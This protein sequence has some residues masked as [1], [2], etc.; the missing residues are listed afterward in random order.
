MKDHSRSNTMA[1][2]TT[3]FFPTVRKSLR[4]AGLRAI[5]LA[6]GL[7]VI[8]YIIARAS[9]VSLIFPIQPGA[10]PARLS[11]ITAVAVSAIG[12]AAGVLVLSLM[13]RYFTAMTPRFP[14]ICAIACLCSLALPLSLTATAATTKMTLVLMHIVATTSVVA[15]LNGVAR[16]RES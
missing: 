16:Q 3:I 6:A 13:R 4:A 2:T 14:L 11:I 8:V 9:S 7:N 10:A 5:A 1:A 12:A 15:M